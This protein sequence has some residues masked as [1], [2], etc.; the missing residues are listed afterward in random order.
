MGPGKQRE[1]IW[2][3]KWKQQKRLGG[4]L[5]TKRRYLVSTMEAAEKARWAWQAKGRYLVWK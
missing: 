5:Q 1:D 4:T 2:F 3:R